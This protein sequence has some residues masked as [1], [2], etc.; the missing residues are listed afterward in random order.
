[1][2]FKKEYLLIALIFTIIFSGCKKWDDSQ[3]LVTPDLGQNLFDAI[4]ANTS[5]SKFTAYIQKSGVDVIL[6]SSKAFTVWA[7]SDDALLSLD[8]AIVSDSAKLRSFVLNHISNQSYFT[9]D[10]QISLR[11]PMLNG[12]YHNFFGTKIEDANITTADK[13]VSNGVLHVIDKPMLVLPNLWDFIN[14]TTAQYLQNS[15]IAGLNFQ[16]FDPTLATIDSISALTGLP[17]YHPGTGV[18]TKNTFN[19]KVF[20]L[21]REDKQYTYFVI[22]NAGFTLK[23]DSLKPYFKATGTTTTDSLDKW[24]IVKDLVVD[25]LYATAAS[26][27]SILISKFGIS[28]PV[29]KTLIIDTKKLSNGVVYVLSLSDVTTASKFQQTI[30]QGE[31][32][33]GFLSDKTGNTN[34]RVRKNLATNQNYTDILVSGHGVTTYYAYY[35]VSEMPSAKYN[36]YALAVNDFQT[37]A[38]TQTI[39]V[40]YLT[41]PI[42]PAT[43][44]PGTTIF[45]TLATLSYAVPLSTAVGA[46][47]EILL[48]QF[49]ST[50]F[51]TLEIRLRAVGTTPIV[52]DYLR[53]VP[54]P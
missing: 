3:T 16:S 38:L 54:I 48:G 51:G 43:T 39:V 9:R 40:N 30:V 7:P 22:A 37:A 6:R 50:S 13:F 10:A 20:D 31:N 17:V 11:I 34:Y 5:L 24:N 49:T 26:I 41:P 28:V 44:P 12:K 19:E 4:A 15:F 47:N 2:R 35:W 25:T 29:N 36:V 53:L 27:P 46:Y 23:A 21:R 45:T 32:P 33:S 52:L 42:P 8:P 18:F 1:M 14:S